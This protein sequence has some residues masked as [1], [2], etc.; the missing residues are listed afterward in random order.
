MLF[1][2]LHEHRLEIPVRIALHTGAR[3]GEVLA[4]EWSSVH[5]PKPDAGERG[6]LTIEAI[7]TEPGGAPVREPWAK[8]RHSVRRVVLDSE[9]EATLRRH[10]KVQREARLA[11]GDCWRSDLV[12]AGWDGRMLR[13]SKVSAEFSAIARMLESAEVLS[14]RGATFHTLRHTLAT[15][16][17]AGGLGM[18]ELSHR[19][20]HSRV[21]TTQTIYVHHGDHDE[22]VAEATERVFGGAMPPRDAHDTRME[23]LK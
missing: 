18:E 23:G 19:L 13:P 8:T 2:A 9:L 16:L 15:L 14:T 10:R 21:T 1:A 5:L 12:C 3:L 4:L 11:L 17:R 7:I 20:G 22:R 6:W